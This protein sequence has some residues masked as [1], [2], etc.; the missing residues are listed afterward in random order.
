MGNK[1]IIL[2]TSLSVVLLIATIVITS[3]SIFKLGKAIELNSSTILE[4]TSSLKS[5]DYRLDWLEDSVYE[6]ALTWESENEAFED[7]LL[8]ILEELRGANFECELN[9]EYDQEGYQTGTVRLYF[10]RE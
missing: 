5:L 6:P 3:L 1:L 7:K 9:L 2:L 10:E 8:K 4:M